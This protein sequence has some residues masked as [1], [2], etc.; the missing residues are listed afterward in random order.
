MRILGDLVRDRLARVFV[1]FTQIW[2]VVC[3]RLC[4]VLAGCWNSGRLACAESM[5]LWSIARPCGTLKKHQ[6]T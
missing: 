2:A 3:D 4:R 6:T 5:A 1:L